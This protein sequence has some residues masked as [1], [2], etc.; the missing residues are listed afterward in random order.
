MSQI[1]LIFLAL[2]VISKCSLHIVSDNNKQF[3]FG[4]L[5]LSESE[6]YDNIWLKDFIKSKPIY[7][8]IQQLTTFQSVYQIWISSLSILEVYIREFNTKAFS[9]MQQ[10]ERECL[11][12]MYNIYNN[13][14]YKNWFSINDIK[15]QT[16]EFKQSSDYNNAKKNVMSSLLGTITSITMS[17]ITNDFISPVYM[18]S[19]FGGNI[20]DYMNSKNQNKKEIQILSEEETI[21]LNEKLFAFSKIYCINSFHLQLEFNQSSNSIIISGDKIDYKWLI[22][23]I[24]VLNTNIDLRILSL[25]SEGLLDQDP[26][27][28]SLISYKQKLNVL[29]TIVHYLSDLVSFSFHTTLQKQLLSSDVGNIINIILNEK[30]NSL[31]YFNNLLIKP[32]PEM[33]EKMEQMQKIMSEHRRLKQLENDLKLFQQ[34]TESLQFKFESNLEQDKMIHNFNLLKHVTWSYVNIVSHTIDF[35]AF[36]LRN[37][38]RH[39]VNLI[40]SIPLGFA[41]GIGYNI[42]DIVFAILNNLWLT[43]LTLFILYRIA[44]KFIKIII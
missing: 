4:I 28:Q 39:C 37:I 11:S 19:K 43:I 40:T 5:N 20:I 25:H 34:E 36:S 9:I 27:I 10:S 30:I 1:M 26:A 12:L 32:F 16:E 15:K 18:A 24:N 21:L 41:E 7:I 31:Q 42:N 8:P 6:F 14:I 35:G 23:L 13:N 29:K 22:N 38:T 2:I 17:T 3:D 33:E 44:K